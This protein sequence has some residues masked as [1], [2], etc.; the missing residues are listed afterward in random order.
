MNLIFIIGLQYLKSF[1][2]KAS[3]VVLVIAVLITV[4]S[5]FLKAIIPSYNVSR[6]RVNTI[7]RDRQKMYAVVN[8]PAYNKTPTQKGTIAGLRTI[9]CFFIGETCSIDPNS[10]KN[11]SKKSFI[12]QL[13]GLVAVPFMNPPASGVYVVHQSLSNFGFLP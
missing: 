2:N 12:G 13:S 4:I 10:P 8:N 5:L 6:S 1:L 9:T 11:N 3:K 7:E